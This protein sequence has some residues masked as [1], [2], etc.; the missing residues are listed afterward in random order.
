METRERIQYDRKGQMYVD[1]QPTEVIRKMRRNEEIMR[2][3][4][5]EPYKY[6]HEQVVET[7]VAIFCWGE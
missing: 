4:V 5:S 1:G 3:R 6:R 2:L 7:L